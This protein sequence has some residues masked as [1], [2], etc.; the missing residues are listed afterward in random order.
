[1]E[2]KTSSP[3]SARPDV[4][5]FDVSEVVGLTGAA[6]RQWKERQAEIEAE[7]LSRQ[8]PAWAREA[9]RRKSAEAMSK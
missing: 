5:T 2:D 9:E 8:Y 6:Y 1:M 4:S 3:Q 7:Q